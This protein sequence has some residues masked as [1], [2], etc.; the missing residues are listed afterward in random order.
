LKIQKTFKEVWEQFIYEGTLDESL[1]PIVRDSWIRS[2]KMG[3]NPFRSYGEIKPI[4]MNQYSYLIDIATPFMKSLFSIVKGSGFMVLICN[5]KG[6]LLKVIGDNEPLKM[7][8]KIGFIV[9]ADWSEQSIGTNAIGTSIVINKPLQIVAEEHYTK[10]CQTWTCSAAPIHDSKG[11]IIGVLNVSGPRE[12]V[13]LHT[14]GMV[15]SSVKA[16]EYQLK[17]H[18]NTHQILRMQKFLE[19]AT[20]NIDECML[21]IDTVGNIIIANDQFKKLFQFQDDQLVHKKLNEIILEPPLDFSNHI[22]IMNKEIYIKLKDTQKYYH[23]IVNKVPI[24]QNRNWLGSMI[25]LKEMKKVRHF[26]NNLTDN[27]AK[28]NF[29]DIIGQTPSFMKKINEAK[30]AAKTS[31]TVLIL[32][33]SGTGKDMIA[34]AIHNESD[35]WNKPFISINCGGIPRDLLGSELFGYEEGAFTGAKKGGSPGKFELADG[36]TLFLDEI[37]EMSLEMQVLLLRVLQDKEVIRIGGQKVIP[38]DV[39]II[40]A[41]NRNLRDEVKKGSFREDLFFRLNVMPIELPPLRERQ[42]DIP[43]LVD[44]FVRKLCENL[45]RP[46][47]TIEPEFIQ[48]LIQ[49][50]WPGNIR[51]LQNILERTINKNTKNTLTVHDL[52]DEIYEKSHLKDSTVTLNR[53]ELKKQSIIHA[54]NLFNGN[55]SKAAKYLGIARSTFYRQMKKYQI[56]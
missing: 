23:C 27:R 17:L 6:Q 31:S 50:S 19:A 14:L 28:I 39:R 56:Q 13:H 32:G 53:H 35:R 51:E 9:K 25:T 2:K 7:A 46:M 16:M 55:I 33:E 36:G 4:D 54:L 20:N 24:Y 18:E 45:S 43:L 48:E 8:K 49:Y 15:V 37:G 1:N 44:F 26:I 47:P 38:V 34:Q 22:R 12:Y 52:P 40:A 41:T 3:I 21:I 42:T 29:H 11:K 5:E 10:I 30:L